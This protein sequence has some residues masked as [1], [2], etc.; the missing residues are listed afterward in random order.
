MTSSSPVGSWRLRFGA[1]AT[2]TGGRRVPPAASD[3]RKTRIDSR[4]T[5]QPRPATRAIAKSGPRSTAKHGAN[6]GADRRIPRAASIGHI[7]ATPGFDGTGW[8]HQLSLADNLRDLERHALDFAERC[9]F[10]YTV[11]SAGT[12][13]VIGCLYI[14]P[15]RGERLGS[16]AG[17]RRPGLRLAAWRAVWGAQRANPVCR[18][19]YQHL[20]SREQNKLRPTQAQTVIAA[21]ILRQRHAVITTGQAWDLE[22]AT[23]GRRRQTRALAA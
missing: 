20:T 17:E 22:I 8:P 19:R 9:G 5:A 21:A 6:G 14:Y 10:T 18:A 23:H 1:D 16:P 4:N 15:P 12:G 3:I 2:R 13:D 7:R 11:L